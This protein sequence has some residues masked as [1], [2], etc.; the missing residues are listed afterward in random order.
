MTYTPVMEVA[1][2]IEKA[3]AGVQL[4]AKGPLV[5]RRAA[6]YQRGSNPIFACILPIRWTLSM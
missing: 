4:L 3:A 2:V 6:M 5:T 1:G